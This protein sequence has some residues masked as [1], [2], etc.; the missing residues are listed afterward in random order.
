MPI[1][2]NNLWMSY[3]A[4]VNT[5]AQGNNLA[6]PD[7]LTPATSPIQTG[8]TKKSPWICSFDKCNSFIGRL[9]HGTW[10]CVYRG[11]KYKVS[12][13]RM[14]SSVS[15]ASF[16]H[17]GY[18][19]ASQDCFLSKSYIRTSDIYNSWF[20]YVCFFRGTSDHILKWTSLDTGCKDVLQE[21]FLQDHTLILSCA[22][23]NIW[24]CPHI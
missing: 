12:F 4:Q 20:S 21:A 10:Q 7:S 23:P 18:P 3:K 19:H 8:T 11:Y 1:W 17:A 24:K 6:R 16:P 13:Y 22:F 2:K 9:C 14:G 5:W 15:P